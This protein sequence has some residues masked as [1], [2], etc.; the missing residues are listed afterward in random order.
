MTKKL[1]PTPAKKRRD[2]D[3]AAVERDYRTGKFTLRELSK[4]YGPS[5]QA[6]GT[7]AKKREWTQDLGAAIKQAT[8]AKLVAELVDKEVAAGG[9]EVAKT[10]LAAAELNKQVILQHRGDIKDAREV[11]AELLQ[12]LKEARLL[13]EHKELLAEI[14]AGPGAE[15]KDQNEARKAV[16]RALGLGS[17]VG[18]LKALAEAFTKLQTAERQAFGLDDGDGDGGEKEKNALGALLFEMG[19]S[20][21]PVV[22]DPG[23]E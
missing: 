9:Q 5:H 20:A 2:T 19:R 11:A 8:N 23:N 21:L 1:A 14:L 18:S 12:E 17:R 3:W 15:P 22:K 6:I 7:Q 10:V 16:A 4:K 13:A